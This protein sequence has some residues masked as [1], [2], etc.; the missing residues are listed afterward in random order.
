MLSFYR[1]GG[2]PSLGSHRVGHD[3]SALAAAAA[4]STSGKE[5]ACQ[6]RRHKR[7]GFEPWVGKIFPR[8]GKG[9]LL[10]YF[11]ENPMERG[12]W[13]AMVRRVAKSQT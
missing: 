13:G 1:L 8:K 2:L 10:Q 6:C 9:N 12:T 4:G 7:H 3:C 11:L 5:P